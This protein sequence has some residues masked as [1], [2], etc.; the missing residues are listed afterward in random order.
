[1]KNILDYIE[2]IKQENEGPR[3]TDQEPR[4]MADG[5]RVPFSYAGIVTAGE[6]KGMH[7][8]LDFYPKGTEG[9]TAEWFDSKKLMNEALQQ[10][11][12][13]RPMGLLEQ[14]KRD[15][16]EQGDYDKALTTQEQIEEL[17]R[18]QQPLN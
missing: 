8:Y 9:S 12:E 16:M 11:K 7:K 10:R 18:L 3:I 4:N 15:Q 13:A 1:M 5:G 6:R 2:K 14:H 17:I